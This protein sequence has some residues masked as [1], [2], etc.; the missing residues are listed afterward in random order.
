MPSPMV[1]S[2]ATEKTFRYLR[3][4]KQLKNYTLLT[5]TLKSAPTG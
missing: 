2:K 4:F 5:V 1:E 3:L